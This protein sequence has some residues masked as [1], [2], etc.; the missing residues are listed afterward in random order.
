MSAAIKKESRYTYKDYCT[1]PDNERWELIDGVPYAMFSDDDVKWEDKNR[2]PYAMSPA[3][4]LGHQAVTMEI[5]RQLANFLHNKPCRVFASPC[6][7]RMNAFDL[8]DTVVQPDILVVCD[9]S[10][11]EDGKSIK[12]APDLAVEVLSPS[13]IN[14]DSVLKLR[15]YQKNRV[16]EYWV[17]D[18]MMKIITVHVLHEE[19]HYM[20][21]AYNEY[22]NAIPI[23]ILEGCEIDL[24][25]LW[26]V[27]L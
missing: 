23:T 12:G 13:S 17:V 19:G 7:V 18:P 16:R 21:R 8:D 15:L 3:L 14:H 6:D 4:S 9:K 2:D 25:L 10:K 20:S 22:E 1:W 5:S 26:T 27:L 24:N 11:L